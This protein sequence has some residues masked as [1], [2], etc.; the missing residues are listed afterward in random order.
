M[1]IQ[2]PLIIDGQLVRLLITGD[3]IRQSVKHTPNENLQKQHAEKTIHEAEGEGSEYES[4]RDASDF[5]EEREHIS[6]LVALNCK[7][8]GQVVGPGANTEYS[9]LWQGGHK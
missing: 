6:V 2:E 4:Q 3:H 7:N 5:C 1:Y 8:Y 9:T